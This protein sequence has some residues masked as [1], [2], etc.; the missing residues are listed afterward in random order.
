VYRNSPIG[1]LKPLGEH[2][3]FQRTTKSDVKP[4]TYAVQPFAA[5]FGISRQS[6]VNDDMGVFSD[7]GAQLA[8]QAAEFENYQ[9]AQLLISNPVMSD[10]NPLFHAAHGN[11]AASG[12]QISS[13]TLTTARLSMR[14]QVNQNGQPIN[15]RPMFLLAPATQETLAQQQLAAIYPIQ[16]N[17]VNVFEDFVR[18]VIDPRLDLAGQTTAWY[19]FADTATVPVLEDSYLSGYEGPRV[20]TRVGFQGG[21]DIDGTEVLCQ[22]DY[23]VGAIGWQ[24]AYKN[25]GA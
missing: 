13:A 6:L 23:G 17:A 9:L 7:I 4:E 11:L 12:G 25:P 3:E 2:G 20:F 10:G 1:Q 14:L 24:G 5:V 21:S 16:T 22:L 19:L 8:Q 15:V 18:L